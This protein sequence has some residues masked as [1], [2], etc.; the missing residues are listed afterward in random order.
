[1]LFYGGLGN[2]NKKLYEDSAKLSEEATLNIRTVYACCY[3]K[4]LG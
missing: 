2:D 4:H 1:M 3:Q